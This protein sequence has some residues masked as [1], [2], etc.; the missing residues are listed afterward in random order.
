[1][2]YIE[3]LR[4]IVGTM[5]LILV[6]SVVLILNENNE[7]LLQKRKTSKYGRFGLPGGLMDLGESCEETAIRE[8]YEETGL[9]INSLNLI[10]VFSGKNSYSK[11]EN[12]DEFYATTLAYYTKDYT[13]ILNPNNSETL[14]L[15]FFKLDN[16]PNNMIGSHKKIIE[17]YN[18]TP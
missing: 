2:S 1:M 8:A 14:E 18:I 6:G 13:G 12:G 9:T 7:V 16:L 3:N 17:E 11:L 15:K 10:N 5:P 4:K